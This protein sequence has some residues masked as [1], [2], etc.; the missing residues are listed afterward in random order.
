[1]AESTRS[2][3]GVVTRVRM[4]LGQV[5]WA[6]AVLAALFLALG[7][8]LIAVQANQDNALVKFVL[9]VA[10]VVDLG[11]FDRD[12]GIKQ[13]T[14]ENAATKNAL[15]NWGIGALAWL[16]VGRILDRILRPNR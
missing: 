5:V 1:M 6:I 9:N 12:N 10:D 4:V 3:P 15:F 11:L 13:F 16:V 7:A 2:N 8:L 14:G